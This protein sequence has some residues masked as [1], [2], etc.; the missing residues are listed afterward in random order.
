MRIRNRRWL[1]ALIVAAT[2]A[3]PVSV[4]AMISAA[5]AIAIPNACTVLSAVQPQNS[6]ATGKNVTPG[7]PKTTS[8]T[9]VGKACSEVVGS[10]TVY[11]DL[12]KYA[13]GW[14]G[15]KVTSETHPSG[16]GASDLLVVGTGLGGG[17]PVDFINFHRAGIYASVSADGASASGLTALARLIYKRL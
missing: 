12:S 11:L 2:V 9:A 4:T 17:G 1:G 14:G 15:V 5:S 6:I 16:L 3:V 13:G 7:K 8:S 10:L